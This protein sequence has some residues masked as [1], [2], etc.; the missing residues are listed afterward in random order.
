MTPEQ[1]QI[2]YDFVKNSDIENIL[3]LGFAHGTSTCY[4]AAALDEKKAG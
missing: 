2:V 3:E 1:G 4:M